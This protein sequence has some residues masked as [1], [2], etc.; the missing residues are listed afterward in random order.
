M[1]ALFYFGEFIPRYRR[2]MVG[3]RFCGGSA[4]LYGTVAQEK[5]DDSYP[6]LKFT[7]LPLTDIRRIC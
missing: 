6:F 7:Y 5:L 1:G 2:D 4:I 3:V